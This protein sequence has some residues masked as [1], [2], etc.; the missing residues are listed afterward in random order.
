MLSRLPPDTEQALIE[1]SNSS[2]KSD[3][4]L[5]RIIQLDQMLSES[6]PELV[7]MMMTTEN[8]D[9]TQTGHSQ[10]RDKVSTAV[11]QRQMEN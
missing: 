9:L 4:K 10:S 11:S 1:A 6:R 3:I 5:D 2:K 8:A 7:H